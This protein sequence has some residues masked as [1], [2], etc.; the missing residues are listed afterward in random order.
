MA[1]IVL[2]HHALG[3]TPGCIAFADALRAAGHV[4]HAPD[5][6]DGR[7]FATVTEGVA[8]AEQVGFETI[9]D[10]G[11]AAADRLPSSIVYAGMSLGVMP[12]QK[13]AQTRSGARGAVL[14]HSTVPLRYFGKW[15]AGVPL[16]IHTMEDDPLGDVD[17]AREVAQSVG[18]AE[19]FLYPGDRH[20]FTDSSLPDH[21]DRGAAELVRQRV[22]AFLDRLA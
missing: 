13:L 16:Q 10:R 11:G 4:V 15:P 19:L 18:G 3:L 14:L 17:V 8:H 5:L 6:Y 12:A 7:T 21:Y 22:L 2:F 1:E 9:I 20:L